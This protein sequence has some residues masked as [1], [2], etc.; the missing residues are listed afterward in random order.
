VMTAAVPVIVNYVT[1]YASLA[2]IPNL[3]SKSTGEGVSSFRYTD[4][5]RGFEADTHVEHGKYDG[6]HCLCKSVG[7]H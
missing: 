4:R 7:S 5:K 2:S 3:M 6:R 1:V